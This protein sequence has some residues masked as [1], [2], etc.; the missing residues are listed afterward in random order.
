MTAWLRPLKIC[1]VYA[2]RFGD[3]DAA[4]RALHTAVTAGLI[5][6]K[7]RNRTMPEW[8]RAKLLPPGKSFDPRTDYGLPPDILLNVEDCAA[9]LQTLNQDRDE[10]E[11]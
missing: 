4:E 8:A 1:E 10:V 6:I 9:A 2:D 11:T 3:M 5:R 7:Y